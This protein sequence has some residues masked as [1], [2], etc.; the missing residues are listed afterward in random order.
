MWPGHENNHE[1]PYEDRGGL[2][3]NQ[4]KGLE[5]AGRFDSTYR[6]I[7]KDGD[8]RWIRDQG[9]LIENPVT[10]EEVID[11]FITDVSDEIQREQKLRDQQTFIDESLNALQDVFYAV[12]KN[13]ELRR[14]NER[15][16][17]VSGYTDEELDGMD[18][19]ELFVDEHRERITESIEEIMKTGSSVVQ[20]D[21]VTADGERRSFEFRGTRL[22]DPLRDEIVAVGIGR[23]ISEQ[24][25]R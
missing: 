9:Q 14:W 7:T 23:D 16:P 5:A 3:S 15:V 25:Q 1:R 6:I 2:W 18:A 11:G 21:I 20:A 4:I 17:A 12:T 10:G 24:A 13:G 19:T 22:T 8:V